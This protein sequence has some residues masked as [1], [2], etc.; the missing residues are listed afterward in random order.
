VINRLLLAAILGALL[1]SAVEL[2]RAAR[3]R[4]REAVPPASTTIHYYVPDGTGI[5][6]CHGDHAR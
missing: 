4:R 1:W 5:H 2:R 3:I 6:L